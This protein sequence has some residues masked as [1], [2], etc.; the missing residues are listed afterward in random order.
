[1]KKL[2][3]IVF[4]FLFFGF[5]TN[6]GSIDSLRYGSFGKV[7]IYHPVSVPEAVVLFVSGDGGWNKGVVDM[8]KNIVTQGALVVGI[9][10]RHYLK[11][12]NS[13]KVKCNYPASDFE[14][15]SLTIQKKY[16]LKQF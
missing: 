14:G 11:N 15:L 10:I 13:S 5:K 3:F 16:K 1:M 2:F 12:I 9:D 8:A 6:A 4:G 7:T